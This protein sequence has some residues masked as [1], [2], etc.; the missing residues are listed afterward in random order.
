MSIA[1]LMI[2]FKIDDCR[3][4]YQIW[5]ELIELRRY[6]VNFSPQYSHLSDDS[7]YGK[8]YFTDQSCNHELFFFFNWFYHLCQ[9]DDRRGSKNNYRVQAK[10][11]ANTTILAI[12]KMDDDVYLVCSWVCGIFYITSDDCVTAKSAPLVR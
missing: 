3:I 10:L 12:S 11:R 2:E 8:N 9:K 6:N 5:K 4:C 7:E 1:S